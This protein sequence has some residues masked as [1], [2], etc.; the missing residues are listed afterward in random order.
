MSEQQRV[1][2]HKGRVIDFGRTAVDYERYR[3]GFPDEFFDRL[4]T[5]GWIAPGI[6]ALDLAAITVAGTAPA[7]SSPAACQSTAAPLP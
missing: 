6:R 2:D 3:P 7:A 1:R 5:A 4:E